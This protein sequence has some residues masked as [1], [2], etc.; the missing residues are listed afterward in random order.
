MFGG[1]MPKLHRAWTAF[2]VTVA[3]T[4]AT[5]LRITPLNSYPQ[6]ISTSRHITQGGYDLNDMRWDTVANS[7]SG[8]S[9]VIFGEVYCLTIYIPEGYEFVSADCS[10]KTATAV[11]DCI[12]KVDLNPVSSDDIVW[13]LYFKKAK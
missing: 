3:P 4:D 10:G 9:K 5:V 8:N 1:V 2:P 11:D 6:L 12:L 7:L 13:K